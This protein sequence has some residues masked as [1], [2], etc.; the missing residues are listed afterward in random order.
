M[1]FKVVLL[2]AILLAA[3]AVSHAQEASGP[4]EERVARADEILS[5]ARAAVYQKVKAAEVKSLSLKDEGIN[6]VES[7]TN[8]DGRTR[9]QVVKFRRGVEQTL[10]VGQ[11]DKL[12]LTTVYF[13][14]DLAPAENYTKVEDTLSG[15]QASRSTH[16]IVN[17]RESDADRLP[18]LPAMPESVKAQLKESAA[19]RTRT[20][21]DEILRTASARLFSLLLDAAWLNGRSLAYVGKAEAG[22]GRA[23]VLEVQASTGRQT[24]FFF[25]ENTHLL[26]MMTDEVSRGG[27]SSKAST[28]FSDYQLMNGLLVA[29]KIYAE[30]ETTEEKEIEVTGKKL[31]ASNVTRTVREIRVTECKVNPK[32]KPGTFAV[33]GGGAN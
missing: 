1:R 25:D 4:N 11:F 5:Q 18:N 20:T 28:Y 29:R 21:K 16:T 22:G 31:R 24:R 8:V 32:F 6:A 26:L 15:E 30:A 17:G 3:V 7:T 33:K 27:L 14:P 12:N 19:R 23:D 2:L 13:N 10:D 9:P